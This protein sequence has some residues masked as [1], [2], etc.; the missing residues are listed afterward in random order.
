MK[1]DA[2]FATPAKL[3]PSFPQYSGNAALDTE[4]RLQCPTCTSH[5]L[6]HGEIIVQ[7]RAGEDDDGTEFRIH[8]QAVQVVARKSNDIPYRRDNLKITFSCEVCHKYEKTLHII[9]HKGHTYIEWSKDS[10][11]KPKHD[12]EDD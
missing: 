4:G 5:Y 2:S 7:N 6:H 9:Q 12:W 1:P 10:F 11:K 3:G 8:R